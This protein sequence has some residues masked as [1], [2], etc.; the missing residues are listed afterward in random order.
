MYIFNRTK[1]NVNRGK[2]LLV[3]LSAFILTACASTRTFEDAGVYKG[4]N[5]TIS[6]TRVPDN[7]SSQVVYVSINGDQ[8]LD[9]DLRALGRDW[10]EDNCERMSLYVNRC[11]FNTQYEGKAVRFV[12]ETDAQMFQQN[13]YYSVYF[14]GVLIRRVTTP[15]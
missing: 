1:L 14:D 10:R 15:L 7:I 3:L 13:A 5:Y 12:E 11:T 8:I 6:I 9:Y 2:T 4:E